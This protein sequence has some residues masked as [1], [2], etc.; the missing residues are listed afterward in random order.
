MEPLELEED[1][2]NSDSSLLGFRHQGTMRAPVRLRRYGNC[3][4]VI[5]FFVIA[6]GVVI[7][8]LGMLRTM[9]GIENSQGGLTTSFD[10]HSHE[11]DISSSIF[12]SVSVVA[13]V[14][15]MS[16][17][18]SISTAPTAVSSIVSSVPSSS[19]A[20][21]RPDLPERDLT[22]YVDT[23]IGTEGYGHCNSKFR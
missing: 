14:T 17:L 9:E 8:P 11:D 15:V 12:A 10:G 6:I 19:P 20:V 7:L 16:S 2:N 22:P 18:I 3:T 1:Q 5:V 13:E 23:L 21:A 4:R